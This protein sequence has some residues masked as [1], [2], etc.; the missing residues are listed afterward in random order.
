MMA[1]L[2]ALMEFNVSRENV[3]LDVT[4]Y[5]RALLDLFALFIFF[6]A[7]RGAFKA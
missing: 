5:R 6:D 3:S 4:V 1:L 7:Q 2:L